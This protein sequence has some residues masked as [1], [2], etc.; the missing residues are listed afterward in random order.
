MVGAT[1]TTMASARTRERLLEAAGE[2]FA[3]RGFQAA[4]VREIC[5]RA[6]ANVAAVN[7]HFGDKE[8]LHAAA[9]RHAHGCAVARFP[10]DGGVSAGDPPEARLRAFVRAF[11]FRILEKGRP[12]WH[13]KLMAREMAEPTRALDALVRDSVRPQ[14]A[15]L[16][17]IVRELL[18]AG[19]SDEA[20]RLSAFS[21][22]GQCLHYHHSREVLARLGSAPAAD[23]AAIERLAGHVTAFSLGGIAS[24]SGSRRAPR[25]KGGET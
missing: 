13:G 9:L 5:R 18:P 22:V 3:E 8:S 21:V 20:V 23:A 6:G 16:S 19:A 17:G 15:A 1:T 2:V 4:T 12:N 25:R 11:L 7:Y 14:F 24:A 10:H